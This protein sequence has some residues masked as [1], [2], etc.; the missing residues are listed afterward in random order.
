MDEVIF[1]IGMVTVYL[2]FYFMLDVIFNNKSL[3]WPKCYCTDR[4]HTA[5]YSRTLLLRLLL[6]HISHLDEGT[7]SPYSMWPNNGL[8]III[9]LSLFSL[10]FLLQ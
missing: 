9:T 4:L 2:L 3:L 6:S 5:L 8:I 7:H 10:Y 1:Y